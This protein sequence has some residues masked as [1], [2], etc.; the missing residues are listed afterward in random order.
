MSGHPECIV[1]S[2]LQGQTR[3]LTSQ[4]SHRRM[5]SESPHR[6]A[7]AVARS[8]EVTTLPTAE[9]IGGSEG[10]VEFSPEIDPAAGCAGKVRHRQCPRP[11]V[12]NWEPVG[13]ESCP[14]WRLSNPPAW[15]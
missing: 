1:T 3:V 4:V 9:G 6:S 13:Q 10:Q 7:G 12:Q 5:P 15:L 14:V 8:P 11:G 2:L